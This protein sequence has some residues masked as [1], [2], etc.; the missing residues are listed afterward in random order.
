MGTFHDDK[1]ALHGITV[2]AQ[3]GETVYVG[4]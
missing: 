4:R 1:G 3:A 2:Y